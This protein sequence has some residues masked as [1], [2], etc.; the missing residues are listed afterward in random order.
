VAILVPHP[1]LRSALLQ[2][3]ESAGDLEPAGGDINGSPVGAAIVEVA[4]LDRSSGTLAQRLRAAGAFVVALAP[5]TTPEAEG[6]AQAA[7]ADVFVRSEDGI[8]SVLE[9]LRQGVEAR[10]RARRGQAAGASQ[11]G[12]SEATRKSDR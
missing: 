12:S 6:L 9:T 3:I 1:L 11:E 2:A 10:A 7:G 5:E 8:D 4:Q